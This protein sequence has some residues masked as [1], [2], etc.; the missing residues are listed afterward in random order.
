MS[1]SDLIS[2]TCKLV[3]KRLV[4][5][6]LSV[7]KKAVGE[8]LKAIRNIREQPLDDSM[9]EQGLHS[10][11]SEPFYAETAYKVLAASEETVVDQVT[12]AIDEN[13]V[14]HLSLD[15]EVADNKGWPCSIL[16]KKLTEQQKK[17][18]VQLKKHFDNPVEMTRALLEHLDDGC[19]QTHYS[20]SCVVESSDGDM[21]F[22]MKHLMG[23]PMH[24]AS[25]ACSSLLRVLRAAAV[26]YPALRTLLQ[27]LYCARRNSLLIDKIELDLSSVDCIPSLKLNLGLEDL[28]VLL[29]Y[30]EFPSYDHHSTMSSSISESHLEVEFD[31]II[32]EF[33]DKLKEDPE[34]TCY[35]CQRL[36]FKKTLTHFDFTAKKFCSSTWVQLKNYLLERDPEVNKNTL[37]VCQHC[38]PILNANNIPGRCV[39]N[40]LYTEPLPKELSDFEYSG[41]P[42]HTTS[43]MFSNYCQTGHLHRKGTH[44]QFTESC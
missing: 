13:A 11:S 16:C 37:Y 40:G 25:D 42:V 17:A 4:H 30:D 7:R 44:L 5:E 34:Y 1:E 32:T 3:A 31:G 19:Q 12:I 8:L 28:A 20:K 18:L 35:S 27:Q 43:Q 2:A 33:K 29:E 10:K 26:H 23:H 36:L 6:N 39:L 21:V 15:D 22:F 38:R 41:E 14:C 24:C 9:F